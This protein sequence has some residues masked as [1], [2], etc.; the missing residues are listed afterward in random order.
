MGDIRAAMLAVAP[1]AP[2]EAVTALIAIAP[3]SRALRTPA[4]LA[5]LIGQCAH[6]SGGFKRTSENLNYSAKRLCQVWPSRFIN[7][8]FASSY[9]RNPEKLANEVY[10]ERM[11]NVN[12]GDGFRFRGRGYLQLTGR[13]NYQEFGCEDDPDKAAEP[14]TAWRIAIQ[15]MDTHSRNGKTAFEWADAGDTAQ[16]G[17]IIN[18]GN[19]GQAE[20]AALTAKALAAL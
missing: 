10:G 19:H 15:F 18:G 14:E 7:Q 11:G 9:A 6:E 3:T 16:V 5:A 12:P 13:S 17:R 1:S 2:D 4:R 20:R 8:E